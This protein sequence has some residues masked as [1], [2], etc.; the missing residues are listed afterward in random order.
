[1]RDHLDQLSTRY[2]QAGLVVGQ[3]NAQEGIPVDVESSGSLLLP[4]LLDERV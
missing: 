3:L 2:T 1:V 4:T